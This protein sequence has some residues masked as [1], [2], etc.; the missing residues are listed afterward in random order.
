MRPPI[1]KAKI[2]FV[3]EP[4]AKAQ[5]SAEIT[6]N[7]LVRVLNDDPSVIAV[8]AAAEI[9]EEIGC[10]GKIVIFER[11]EDKIYFRIDDGSRCTAR[12]GI[13]NGARIALLSHVEPEIV[14]SDTELGAEPIRDS[15]FLLGKPTQ[16]GLFDVVLIDS[17]AAFTISLIEKTDAGVIEAALKPDQRFHRHAPEPV[18]APVVDI[19]ANKKALVVLFD[20]VAFNGKV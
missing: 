14:E 17:L 2:D 16:I 13:Y 6:G 11:R 3:P 9:D 19:V 12:D 20:A 15:D 4:G 7:S 1:S 10:I 5:F 18:V 8:K